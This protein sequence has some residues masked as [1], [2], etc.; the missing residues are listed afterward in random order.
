MIGT[1][2]SHYRIL[3]KLGA[4]GMG[5]VYK[6]ED[7]RLGRTV[8]LKF[9]PPELS[10]DEDAKER[11]IREARSAS[12]LDHPTICTIHEIG[13]AEDGRLFIAMAS[14]AGETL[15]KRIE[16]GPLLIP[17]AVRI[18]TQIADGLVCAHEHGIIHRD[19]KPA[20]VMLLD[21]GG[22]KIV[23]FGL[24]KLAKDVSITASG[25]V[26]GTLAYMSPEQ[27]RGADLDHRAD[28][29]V[30]GSPAYMP[31]EQLRNATSVDARADLWALG[32]VLYEMVTGEKPH[33]N[34]PVEGDRHVPDRIRQIIGRLL[35]NDSSRR[36]E[37]ARQLAAD[38]RVFSD[39][40]EMA[41]TIRKTRIPARRRW[42]LLAAIAFLL[43]VAAVGWI[44]VGRRQLRT[45]PP[46]VA[47]QQ[48][49][50]PIVIFPFTIHG[51]ADLAYLGEG[52]L[53]LL[54][55][56]LDGVGELR[57]VEPKIILDHLKHE[58]ITS[59]NRETARAMS[60]RFGGRLYIIGNCVEAGGRL[61]AEA[62]LYDSSGKL[63]TTVDAS[64]ENEGQ[65]FALVDELGRKLLASQQFKEDL[66]L[67][68]VAAETTS[69]LE[70]LKH[71]LEG[72]QYLRGFT[73]PV[74]N[75]RAEEH[76]DAAVAL[77]PSFTL[78]WCR[79]GWAQ[80][81]NN[82][83][84]EAWESSQKAARLASRLSL[85][86]RRQ[87]EVLDAWIIGNADRA[88]QLERT[89]IETY[90]DDLEAWTKLG[91]TLFHLNAPRARRPAEARQAF[92]RVLQLN[93]HETWA[94]L[95]LR[96]I[97]IEQGELKQL[98]ALS[99]YVDTPGGVRD[100]KLAQLFFSGQRESVID[101]A[102][103]R[104]QLFDAIL[105]SVYAADFVSAERLLQGYQKQSPANR[106]YGLT[107]GA[108][109][110]AGRGRW[111]SA[112][113]RLN[114]ATAFDPSLALTVR[115]L[116][117]G[118]P[119]LPAKDEELKQLL[120][121]LNDW[122]QSGDQ[123]TAWAAEETRR[124]PRLKHY[125]IGLIASRL[126]NR[127]ATERAAAELRRISPPGGSPTADFE[128]MIT[129]FLA[130]LDG[131]P[132]KALR[133]IEKAHVGATGPVYSNY[134]FLHYLHADLLLANGR[135]EEALRFFDSLIPAYG[136]EQFAFSAM[137]RLRSAEIYD[138][139][140]RTAEAI[141]EYG[142]FVELWKDCDPELRPIVENA[143]ARLRVLSSNA[144][145][146]RSPAAVFVDSSA[147]GA[148]KVNATSATRMTSPSRSSVGAPMR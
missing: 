47:A 122:V 120:A 95:H 96:D 134:P 63:Q 27:V 124:L 29:W 41:T 55:R 132:N 94:L 25:A 20:N 37:T 101:D 107:R 142:A 51:R 44:V 143:R 114:Q 52:M 24:A 11:F 118:T 56:K 23:D 136:L 22:L 97:A 67:G 10:H 92:E 31:P 138:R 3:A 81:G 112:K 103:Q 64:A 13:E 14:Y 148:R 145:Y 28:L 117:Y 140:S 125:L 26:V 93:P 78:A 144:G 54:G 62:S 19:I 108:L 77:D 49:G 121:S 68:R 109:M 33:G 75:Q 7:A 9:L 80:L 106:A 91:E 1:T 45:D 87:L 61:R 85:R 40:S 139:T 4:G 38:L 57:T 18:A 98:E 34:D 39:T 99:R 89:A 83:N 16:R 8:A 135:S 86:D 66:R 21:D 43:V 119:F 115:S 133:S 110:D 141:R 105:W 72:E 48:A 84:E 60:T 42:S 58:K 90:P 65:L 70:A 59:V 113:E 5:V 53:D 104:E 111:K 126:R 74:D 130:Q 146:S 32:V 129:A 123:Q 30:L 69:S 12:A 128:V 76:F 102:L 71:F 131:D 35:Q 127:P 6:A 100:L 50:I 73:R 137:A 79:L 17:A 15:K 147:P 2:V 88:E 36:Y 46:K 116:L 82:K